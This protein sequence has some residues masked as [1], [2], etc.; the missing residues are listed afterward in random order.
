MRCLKGSTLTARGSEA[1]N[2][3]IITSNQAIKTQLFRFDL[4]PCSW[5]GCTWPKN[6]DSGVHGLKRRIVVTGSTGYRGKPLIFQEKIPYENPLWS[7]FVCP[8]QGVGPNR[9]FQ[10][11]KHGQLL[12]GVHDETLPRSPRCASAIQIVR[13]FRQAFAPPLLGEGREARD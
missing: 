2:G 5:R 8:T 13:P 3:G 7:L 12:I 10:F 6:R 1:V 11:Q 4:I 9:W